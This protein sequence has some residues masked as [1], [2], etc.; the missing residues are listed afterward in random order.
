[1][2]FNLKG[3]S[4]RIDCPQLEELLDKFDE[5]A[6]DVKSI[7]KKEKEIMGKLED[8]LKKVQEITVQVGVLNVA[9]DG[10]RAVVA[11]MQTDLAALKSGEI[12]SDVVAN[13]VDDIISNAD[14]ALAA[15]KD[16]ML[17]NFPDA[18]PPPDEV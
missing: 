9:L 8:A 2:K 6:K 16:T 1:M 7:L 11:Q 17:E 12:L 5:L 3:I 18:P 10:T 14:V 13:K 15:V 4:L